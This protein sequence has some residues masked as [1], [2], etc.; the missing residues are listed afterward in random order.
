[1]KGS[2]EKETKK[3]PSTKKKNQSKTVTKRTFKD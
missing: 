3:T 2:N 1:M